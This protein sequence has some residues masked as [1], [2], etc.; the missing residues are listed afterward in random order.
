[1]VERPSF[2][3]SASYGGFEA[4]VARSAKAEAK[5]IVLWGLPQRRDR[6]QMVRQGDDGF[7]VE[8]MAPPNMANAR[9]KTIVV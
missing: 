5:P 4:A 2:A 6:M 1:M 3:R 7:D 9:R 8:R